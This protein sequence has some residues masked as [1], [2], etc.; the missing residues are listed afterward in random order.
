MRAVEKFDHRRGFKFSTYATWWIRQAIGRAI[1]D[2]ARTIRVPAHVREQ[3]VA[4]DRRRHNASPPTLDREPTVESSPRDTGLTPDR[5]EADTE[6]PPHL[7]SLSAPP[8]RTPTP[9]WPTPSPIRRRGSLRG[10]RRGGWT[11]CACAR[12]WPRLSEREQRVLSLRFGLD[13][14]TSR[15][16]SPRSVRS[17]TSPASASARSRRRRSTKLRHPCT[18]RH[19]RVDHPVGRAVRLRARRPGRPADARTR[20]PAHGAAVSRCSSGAPRREPSALRRS[21]PRSAERR[22]DP[23]RSASRAD[24]RRRR[25]ARPRVHDDRRL[26]ESLDVRRRLP[27]TPLV[28]PPPERL[29]RGGAARRALPSGAGS[30]GARGARRR[31]PAR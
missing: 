19:H 31:R 10:S 14:A 6:P 7:L 29:H 21:R 9:S 22:R 24:R 13:R 16:R 15:R 8:V 23:S 3:N 12:G 25:A 1:A 20:Q 2:K 28:A 5:V 17:S 4:A 26:T 27:R 11:R 30:C 18:A